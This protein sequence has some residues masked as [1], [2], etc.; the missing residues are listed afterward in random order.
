MYNT[1]SAARLL[2]LI[3]YLFKPFK[4]KSLYV[5]NPKGEAPGPIFVAIGLAVK[6]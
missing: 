3:A 2:Y 6:I 1:S 4:R 5:S